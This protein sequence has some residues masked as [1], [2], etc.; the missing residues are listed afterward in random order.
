MV[1][2]DYWRSIRGDRAAP[3]RAD[4]DLRVMRELLPRFNLLDVHWEP[5]RFR[6]RLV[7][8]HYVEVLGRDVTG[9]FVDEELYGEAASEIFENLKMVA[10]EVR[11]YR[12]MARLEWL[13]RKG[14]MIE[15]AEL[16]LVDEDDRVNMILRVSSF[17]PTVDIETPRLSYLPLE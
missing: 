9:R 13:G 16:P 17:S 5:L 4:L 14:L 2:Y 15:S 12:R 6:H 11:P 7:G 3:Q 8:S 1:A 10:V